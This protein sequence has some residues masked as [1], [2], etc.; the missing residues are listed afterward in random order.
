[1]GLS[2]A[3]V[4]IL[5]EDDNLR[6][7]KARIVHRVEDCEHIGVDAL[8]SVLFDEKG[9]QFPIIRLCH[10]IRKQFLPIVL[11]NFLCHTKLSRRFQRYSLL[12]AD[13]LSK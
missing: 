12:R 6:L 5:S 3:V 13:A 10:L 8:R 7:R 4:R 9:A 11:E 1:M 2:V